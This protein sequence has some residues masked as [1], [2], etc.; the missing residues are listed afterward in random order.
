MNAAT[1][2]DDPPEHP[3]ITLLRRAAAEAEHFV[4]TSESLAP[5]FTLDPATI[6]ADGTRGPQPQDAAVA[7]QDGND[8]FTIRQRWLKELREQA[9]ALSKEDIPWFTEQ[10]LWEAQICAEFVLSL[11]R[12]DPMATAYFGKLLHD[13]TD[14]LGALAAAGDGQAMTSLAGVATNAAQHLHTAAMHQPELVREVAGHESEWPFLIGPHGDNVKKAR[15][16]VA[17]LGLGSKAALNTKARWSNRH[18]PGQPHRGTIGGF[19]ER[20]M[21]IM[22]EIRHI[23]EPMRLL[24]HDSSHPALRS[25]PKWLFLVAHLPDIESEEGATRWFEAAWQLLLDAT[26]GQPEKVPQ[27]AGAGLGRATYRQREQNITANQMLIEARQGLKE[28]MLKAFRTRYPLKS[29]EE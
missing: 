1:T 16:Y 9:E 4:L 24:S 21:Q 18:T 19:L 7:G 22:A 27:F 11:G 20:A 28:V 5:A 13:L 23:H 8:G 2:Q 3:A 6:G 26:N 10:H 14:H 15:D 25:L 29:A 12:M 17:H